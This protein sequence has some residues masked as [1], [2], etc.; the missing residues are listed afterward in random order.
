MERLAILATLNST[1]F[2]ERYFIHALQVVFYVCAARSFFDES[3]DAGSGDAAGRVL[4][5]RI[6]EFARRMGL[7]RGGNSGTDRRRMGNVFLRGR[8]HRAPV[9]SGW[10]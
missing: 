10:R 1:V 2:P 4:Y 6:S 7:E 8:G 9:L 5:R 3:G